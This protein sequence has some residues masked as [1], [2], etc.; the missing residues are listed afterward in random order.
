MV[1]EILLGY[2]PRR[3]SSVMGI[4]DVFIPGTPVPQGSK[5]ISRY[6]VMYDANK[7]LGPWRETVTANTTQYAG[8]FPKPVPVRAEYTF[9]MPRP[10]TVKRDRPTVPPDLD[11]L[12]RAVNDALTRAGVWADDSQLV[13]VRAMKCYASDTPG[14]RIRLSEAVVA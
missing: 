12:E 5:S 6:G 13:E 10:K 3:I 9:Y 4:V 2:R 11:K 14:V 1:W 7:K 8:V